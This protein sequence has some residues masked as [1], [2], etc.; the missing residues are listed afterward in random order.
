MTHI[1][2]IS[3]I[4]QFADEILYL[5]K[6]SIDLKTLASHYISII[7]SNNETIKFYSTIDSELRDSLEKKNFNIANAQEKINKLNGALNKIV[8]IKQSI[9]SYD[10][11]TDSVI[12]QKLDIDNFKQKILSQI[13][14][15][16]LAD[17]DVVYNQVIGNYNE[18]N[19]QTTYVGEIRDKYAKLKQVVDFNRVI[20]NTFP[21]V[22]KELTDFIVTMG[23]DEYKVDYYLKTVNE[24]LAKLGNIKDDVNTLNRIPKEDSL[25]IDAKTITNIHGI[26]NSVVYDSAIQTA[27][28]ARK[29]I[30]VINASLNKLQNIRSYFKQLQ[31]NLQSNKNH[32]FSDEY[33]K[34]NQVINHIQPLIY[35]KLNPN[36]LS[37]ESQLKQI[38]NQIKAHISDFNTKNGEAQNLLQKLNTNK[39]KYWLED[40][41][42][43]LSKIQSLKNGH[44]SE[45]FRN[46]DN[47]INVKH[48]IKSNEIDSFSRQNLYLLN[49]SGHL[50]ILNDNYTN[51][52]VAR[53]DFEKFAS[54]FQKN[55]IFKKLGYKIKD[56][57]TSLLKFLIKP[58]NLK[59]IGILIAT[60]LG[61]Y[62]IMSF[63][64]TILIIG[65]IVIIIFGLLKK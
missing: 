65:I 18:F 55:R 23:L 52:L 29:N 48:Q 47:E 26:P 56:I 43:I 40:H 28:I 7:I 12:R 20:L 39:T 54:S 58:K 24:V 11:I 30:E 59:F 61:I 14:Q 5:R 6:S 27:D 9:N 33:N 38:D 60:A 17:I 51:S 13:Q 45:N 37:V 42:I 46:I 4:S 63:W 21:K 44:K 22:D 53:S 10:T 31:T 3:K 36:F 34:A 49:A 64:P 19:L 1:Q 35:A 41:N 32:I 16:K 62:F 25:A 2:N 15:V 8:Y 50:S 57:V